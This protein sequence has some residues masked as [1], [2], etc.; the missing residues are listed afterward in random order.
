MKAKILVSAF[1]AIA[2]LSGGLFMS[3][4]A[5]VNQTLMGTPATRAVAGVA[6]ADSSGSSPAATGDV[7]IGH[8]GMLNELVR[9]DLTPP[10]ASRGIA[11][12]SEG[13][14]TLTIARKIKDGSLPADLFGSADANANKLLTGDANGNKVRWFAAFARAEMVVAYSPNSQFRAEFE[15][16]QRG[17]QP[18]YEPLK[19]PGVTVARANPDSD[20]SGYFTLLVAQLAEKFSGEAGLKQ[21]ILGDDRNPAQVIGPASGDVFGK[22]LRGEVDALFM[23]RHIAPVFG[24]PFVSLPPRST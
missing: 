6:A 21:Q 9:L 3:A 20:P 1:L 18:W 15:K 23:Y 14:N 24:V 8:A 4:N 16:A 11:I 17:E 7:L 13:G 5:S 2:M 12:K 22:F 19:L 10:L